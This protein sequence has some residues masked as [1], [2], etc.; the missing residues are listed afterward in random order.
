MT[1]QR[2]YLNFQKLCLPW[3]LF[4]SVPEL[5]QIFPQHKLE[6]KELFHAKLEAMLFLVQS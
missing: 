3:E 1:F 5:N 2:N 4:R 6:Y